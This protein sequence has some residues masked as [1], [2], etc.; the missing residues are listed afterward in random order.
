MSYLCVLFYENFEG[1]RRASHTAVVL[2]FP[3]LKM[4]VIQNGYYT[5]VCLVVNPITVDIYGFLFNCTT[6]GHTSDLMT[7]LT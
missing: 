4:T 6:V 7:T 3:P 2:K 5:A 1:N